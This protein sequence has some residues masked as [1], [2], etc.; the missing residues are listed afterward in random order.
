MVMGA[1]GHA[2]LTRIVLGGT[3]RTLMRSMTLPVLMAH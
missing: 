3:T 2:R 1:Y